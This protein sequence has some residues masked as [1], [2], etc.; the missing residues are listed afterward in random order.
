MKMNKFFS[1]LAFLI[2]VSISI[3]VMAQVSAQNLINIRVD[4]LSDDQVRAFMRQAEASGMGDAQLEQMAQAR[5]MRPEEIKKLRERVDKLKKD[6]KKQSSDSDPNKVK[7]K[8]ESGDRAMDFEQD[9]TE[10]QK[11][12]ETEAEKAFNELRSK[13]FGADLFKSSKLTFEPNLSIA[14]PKNYVVGPNDELLIDI[15]GNSEASYNL[16]VSTEGNINVEYV[17]I[18]H[19]AGLTIEAATSRIRSRLS[20]VYSGLRNGSTNLNIA[21]GNI[22][23]IKV[24]LIGEI[25]KP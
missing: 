3:P 11:D 8:K 21:V 1:L 13:I 2:L 17:G 9:S 14:T 25:V 22:R 16:K 12:P 10:V 15:Y 23:S 20:T 19:V 4:E 18:V 6:D 7:P 5:G 24:I